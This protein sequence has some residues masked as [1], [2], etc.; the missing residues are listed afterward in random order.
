MARC[1][2]SANGMTATSGVA[3]S[4]L[5]TVGRVCSGQSI[6][7]W[8]DRAAICVRGIELARWFEFDGQAQDPVLF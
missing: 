8:R 7:G 6:R 1:V 3:A 4:G 2:P 5:G